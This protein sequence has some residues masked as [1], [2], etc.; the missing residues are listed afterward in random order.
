[1]N[2]V[3]PFIDVNLTSNPDPL[4]NLLPIDSL[5]MPKLLSQERDR[6]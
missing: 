6:F 5:T 2:I 4:D 3:V 1:M